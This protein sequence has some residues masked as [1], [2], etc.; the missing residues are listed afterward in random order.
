M[1]ARG[2]VT[3]SG[4][5]GL[6]RERPEPDDEQEFRTFSSTTSGPFFCIEFRGLDGVTESAVA[7]RRGAVVDRALLGAT[8]LIVARR[9]AVVD[10]GVPFLDEEV[11]LRV[12]VAEGRTRG[13]TVADG[14]P[15]LLSREALVALPRDAPRAADA[16]RLEDLSRLV[17]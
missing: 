9:G 13:P 15:A 12:V 16:G 2:L 10:L 3:S 7:R 8:P 14:R 6:E 17:G 1:H 5:R 11:P 4:A